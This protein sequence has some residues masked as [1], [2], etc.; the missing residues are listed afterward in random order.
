MPILYKFQQ[1]VCF[2][3]DI[4][5]TGCGCETEIQ[6]PYHLKGNI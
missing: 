6:R 2:I 3:E 4:T 1:T 5:Y